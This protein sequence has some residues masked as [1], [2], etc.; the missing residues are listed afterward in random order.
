MDVILISSE[1]TASLPPVDR[2]DVN[3]VHVFDRH[4]TERCLL[5][6]DLLQTGALNSDCR[7]LKRDHAKKKK[8]ALNRQGVPPKEQHQILQSLY[9]AKPFSFGDLGS[10]AQKGCKGC[11]FIRALIAALMSAHSKRDPEGLLYEW[12]RNSFVLS[13]KDDRSR[14]S[15]CFELFSPRGQ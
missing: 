8:Q 5:R 3:W 12:K 7:P 2:R 6:C 11:L 10:S 4:E 14:E 13:V 15:F 1:E 9:T